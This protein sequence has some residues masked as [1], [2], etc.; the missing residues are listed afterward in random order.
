[1]RLALLLTFTLSFPA[2]AQV[3]TWKDESGTTHYGGQPPAGQRDEV[4]IRKQPS[5]NMENQGVPPPSTDSDTREKYDPKESSRRSLSEIRRL[6]SE[7]ACKLAKLE[8]GSAERLLTLAFSQNSYD[9]V[10]DRR[11]KNVNHWRKRAGIHCSDGL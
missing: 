10:M 3:Y 8:L 4:K 11:K 9:F 2:L 5:Q 6:A 1:M 7:R